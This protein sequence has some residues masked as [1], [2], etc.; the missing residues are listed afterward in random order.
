MQAICPALLRSLVIEGTPF[1]LREL[2]PTEDRLALEHWHGKL[3]R[4]R[5]LMRT[6]GHVVAWAQLRSASREGSATIDELIAFARRRDWQRNVADTAKA[7]SRVVERAFR[8][9][10]RATDQGPSA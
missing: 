7:Y 3:G 10:R 9:F 6:I 2:Q 8:A 4:L 5:K 1:V